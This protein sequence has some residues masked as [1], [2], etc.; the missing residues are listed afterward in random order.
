MVLRKAVTLSRGQEP[1]VTTGLLANKLNSYASLLAA[2]GS[3]DTAI[4]YLGNSTEVS[5]P[6]RS[7]LQAEVKYTIG[8]GYRQRSS[9]P[10][11]KVTG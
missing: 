5:H 1:E 2:Q 9:T 6:P 4:R 3:M 8:Q 10:M 7:R 11:V